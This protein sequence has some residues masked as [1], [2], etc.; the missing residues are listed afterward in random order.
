M[1]FEALKEQFIERFQAYKSQVEDSA[2][3]ITL[4]DRYDTL[5]P[6]MQNVVKYAS[7][8]FVIYFFYSIPA[9]FVSS[10]SEKMEFF[11]ENRAMTRELIRAGRIAQTVQLPPP[12]PTASAL[13]SRVNQVLEREQILPEQKMA[14]TQKNTVASKS[15][16]P[17]AIKQSGVK[18]SVKQ[19]NLRQLIRVGEALN[20][21]DSTRLMNIAI[22]ADAKDPHYFV[23]DYE[24]AAFEVPRE[25]S[26]LTG[27]KSNSKFKSRGNSRKRK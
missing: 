1:D 21:I 24:V 10:A 3:Y 26:P 12:A 25:E 20:Q 19:L 16:V 22:Q 15:L 6:N 9:S 13:T 8:F 11:E 17:K 5:N 23:V 2:V 27:K 18:V 7:L 4:K 14:T